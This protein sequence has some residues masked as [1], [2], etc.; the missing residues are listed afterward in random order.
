MSLPDGYD[1]CLV[2]ED[3]Q[4]YAVAV[5]ER[6]DGLALRPDVPSVQRGS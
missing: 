6:N 4:L 5:A 2:T 1:W 3:R